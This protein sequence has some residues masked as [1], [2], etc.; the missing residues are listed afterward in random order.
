MKYSNHS[1]FLDFINI[2]LVLKS[3]VLRKQPRP[4]SLERP[5]LRPLDV[6]VKRDKV[7]ETSLKNPKNVKYSS[8]IDKNP[9]IMPKNRVKHSLSEAKIPVSRTARIV[10]FSKLFTKIS[11]QNSK[12]L[13]SRISTSIKSRISGKDSKVSYED[14]GSPVTQQIETKNEASVSPRSIGDIVDT[15][16][17]LRGAALKVGQ[18]LS[19]QD[20]EQ[21]PKEWTIILSKLQNQANYISFRPALKTIMDVDIGQKFR[22]KYGDG[23]SWIKRVREPENSVNVDSPVVKSEDFGV[24]LQKFL[25]GPMSSRPSSIDGQ[26]ICLFSDFNEIP[27]AAASIGQVHKA[28][29]SEYFVASGAEFQS[30]SRYKFRDVCVKIQYPG[31][32]KS[33]IS[34]LSTLKVFSGTL[35]RMGLLPRGLFLDKTIDVVRDEIK[36]ELDY[37]TEAE[38]MDF[39]RENLMKHYK[40]WNEAQRSK[41]PFKIPQVVWEGCS[42]RVLTAEWMNGQSFG[43]LNRQNTSQEL[44]DWVRFLFLSKYFISNYSD[45]RA[46]H[47]TV[48]KGT[49]SI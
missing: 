38:N 35:S 4:I 22:K 14:A 2:L 45:W 9:Q 18:M 17:K 33:I 10:E 16:S 42:K 43:E 27:V 37:I 25:F 40:P 28:N 41:F 6:S 23:A 5:R 32:E 48:F 31:I 34:D 11:V 13:L 44:R 7:A 49:I 24:Q 39:F 47:G 21:L 46:Y 3:Q 29:L 1:S 20:S 19:I 30:A 12:Y 26:D 15:L 8:N 36:N